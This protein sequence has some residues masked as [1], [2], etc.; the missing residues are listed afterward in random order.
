MTDLDK[1][2]NPT[3]VCLRTDIPRCPVC[4][5]TDWDSITE[6]IDYI[7]KWAE[8]KGWNRE[9]AFADDMNLFHTEISEAYEE[10][11][12]YK[13]IGEV[14]YS[15]DEQGKSKPEGIAI[16][17]ADLAIRILHFCAQHHLPLHELIRLKMLYNETRPERHGGKRT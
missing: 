9:R 3:G 13:E 14:Y 8:S 15:V 10:H 17:I 12:K 1:C 2:L 11:R 7:N 6:L 5:P 16:E 4:C